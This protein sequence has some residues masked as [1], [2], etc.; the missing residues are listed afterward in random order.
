MGQHYVGLD[1][2]LETTSVCVLDEAGAVV[3]RGKVAST[4]EAIAA[5]VRVRAPQVE[6][7]GLETGPLCTWHWHALR[8]AGLPVVCL[9]A[10]HAKAALSMQL[11][12]TD[13]NDAHGLAQIVRTGWYREVAVKRLDDH[14]VRALLSSRAQLVDLRRDLGTKTRGLL[15]TFGRVVGKVGERG[16]EA[17][18][19]ELAAGEAGLEEAVSALLA[20]RERLEQQIRA[21]DERILELAR[22]SDACRRLTTIPGVG[23]LT[24]L[25]FVAAVGDPSRFRKS[26]TVGAYFGLTPRRHQSGETDYDG[27]ISR[28]GDVLTRTYL[29]EAAGVLLARVA[30]WSALKAWGRRLAKRV[31]GK[32]A[33]VAPARKLAVL[34][35][36]VWVGGTEFRWSREAATA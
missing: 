6:R 7:I 35:H 18:V 16:Y 5:A 33:R 11:N 28:C 34:M 36:R 10:R 26:S 8:Q 32:K 23:T 14:R 27:E 17:R 31:G 20:V 24:A 21:L 29:F 25:S 19:R 13:A 15:K 1:V 9:D 3:W 30:R 4:P 12:K 2:S 22:R